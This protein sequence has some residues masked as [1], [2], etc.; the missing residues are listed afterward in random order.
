MTT[1]INA[2]TKGHMD[3]EQI[4]VA[5]DQVFRPYMG[6]ASKLAIAKTAFDDAKAHELT[7][8]EDVMKK[9]AEL[10]HGY[11]WGPGAVEEALGFVTDAYIERNKID[12]KDKRFASANT[13]KKDAA[14]VC[15]PKVRAHV[16]R[17]FALA[18][19]AFDAKDEG[20]KALKNAFA[21][22]YQ[23]AIACFVEIKR[24]REFDTAHDLI[25]FASE[26]LVAR[27][28][29]GD[30]VKRKFEA[31]VEG[32]RE[33][34]REFPSE[35]LA[36]CIEALCQLDADDFADMAKESL[37][38]RMAELNRASEPVAPVIATV[39]TPTPA[40]VPTA[41]PLPLP[42]PNGV[43]AAMQDFATAG[44]AD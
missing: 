28:Y 36:K 14:L 34:H 11:A 18:H 33:F 5:I 27:R 4:K 19:T 39:P 13:F 3:L 25:Q 2:G 20:S 16:A 32:V 24:G 40:P 12:K 43:D 30:A 31:L 8:R 21:R 6:E 41:E 44:S 37:R 15:R 17:I 23:C 10:S 35:Y 1:V 22:A 7:G 29:D 38:R 26:K 9:L 42:V